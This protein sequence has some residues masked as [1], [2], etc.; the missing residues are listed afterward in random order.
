L[1]NAARVAG[2]VGLAALVGGAHADSRFWAP[3]S[4]VDRVNRR[5]R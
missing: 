2:F 3:G 1:A 5:A 4:I